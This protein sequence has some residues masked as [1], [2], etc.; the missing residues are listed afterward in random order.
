PILKPSSRTFLMA[1]QWKIN[2]YPQKMEYANPYYEAQLN[3]LIRMSKTRFQEVNLNSFPRFLDDDLV[4]FRNLN[5]SVFVLPD[6][7]DSQAPKERLIKLLEQKEI[8]WLGI[9][10]LPEDFQQD[11]DTFIDEPEGTEKFSRSEARL[12]EWLHTMWDPAIN[13][14]D[15]EQG[16]FAIL[17]A[18]K[19]LKK[20]VIAID[21]ATDYEVSVE[22]SNFSLRSILLRNSLWAERLPQ[23]GHGI[24]F[25]GEDHFRGPGEEDGVFNLLPATAFI[26]QRGFS[27]FAPQK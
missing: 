27:I 15:V 20:R 5:P 17:K 3:L 4:Q 23:T 13:E 19:R 10:M 18:A 21:A 7:H 11:L 6:N 25:G 8:E 16:Y 26:K 9:E 12:K 14:Q 24:I 22:A 1:S 2:T